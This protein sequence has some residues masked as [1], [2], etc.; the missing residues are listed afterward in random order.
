MARHWRNLPTW[1]RNRRT[2]PGTFALLR[3]VPESAEF[4][5]RPPDRP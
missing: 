4:V 3:F 5:P 1:L 2:R